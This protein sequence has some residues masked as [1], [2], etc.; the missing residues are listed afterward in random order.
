MDEIQKA[1]DRL[2]RE[3][4]VLEQMLQDHTPDI[5][6]INQIVNGLETAGD[7]ITSLKYIINPDH[8]EIGN[9]EE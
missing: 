3:I 8:E 9:D 6:L 5:S 4:F 1:L 2:R 7:E